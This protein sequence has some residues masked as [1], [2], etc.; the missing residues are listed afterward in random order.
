MN[1]FIT[2]K[3]YNLLGEEIATL[4]EHNQEAGYH[5]IEF[6][7]SQL[8]SGMYFYRIEAGK[9]VDTKKMMVVK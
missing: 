9:F 6:N 8:P 7:A 3:V 5:Q 2:I 4:V 1:N